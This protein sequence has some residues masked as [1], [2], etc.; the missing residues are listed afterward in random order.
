[1]KEEVI[2]SLNTAPRH[3]KEEQNA[4]GEKTGGPLLILPKHAREQSNTL[5]HEHSFC[6]V[7]PLGVLRG[8]HSTPVK[9]IRPHYLLTPPARPPF[10]A[11]LGNIRGENFRAH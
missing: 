4:V 3:R 9:K 10:S 1:M 8:L 2:A 7:T 6:F 11:T 5:P